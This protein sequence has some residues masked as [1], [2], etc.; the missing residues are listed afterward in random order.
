MTELILRPGLVGGNDTYLN[1]QNPT[2]NFGG[3]TLGQAGV[4]TEGK[5]TTVFRSIFHFSGVSVIPSDAT[6]DSASLHLDKNSTVAFE[7]MFEFMR[8]TTTGFVELEA[9]WESWKTGSAWTT[10]GGDFTETDKSTI[11]IDDE[12]DLIFD[13]AGMIAQVKY[14][15]DNTVEFWGLCKAEFE[16]GLT[17]IHIHR[18][19][20]FIVNPVLRPELTI[21]YTELAVGESTS[22]LMDL[23]PRYLG[24]PQ[25]N[26]TYR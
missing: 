25:G 22:G 3:G 13:D 12:E 24:F 1:D 21:N 20:E 7:T 8:L 23:D 5:L 2:M 15:L 10:P 19:S 6:I 14:C 11:I 16:V 4:I 26:E 17:H 9:T 18:M